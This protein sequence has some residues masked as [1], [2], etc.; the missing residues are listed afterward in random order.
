MQELA[1]ILVAEDDQT[2]IMILQMAARQAALAHPLV[3]VSDGSQ[4]INYLGG[5]PPFTDRLRHPLPVLLILDLKMP[6]MTGF[7]VLSWLS[8]RTELKHLPAVVLTSSSSESDIAKAR[9]LG[10]SDYHVKPHRI[11]D[12]VGLLQSINKRWLSC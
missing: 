3:F 2:D 10:A 8:T 12:L 4:A 7:D 9:Q 11:A 5:E 6:I 1:P